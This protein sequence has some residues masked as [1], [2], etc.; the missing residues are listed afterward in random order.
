MRRVRKRRK[1]E[2]NIH[3]TSTPARNQNINRTST[4]TLKHNNHP[5]LETSTPIERAG[6]DYS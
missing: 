3:L 5:P 1:E 2:E 6:L 4:D